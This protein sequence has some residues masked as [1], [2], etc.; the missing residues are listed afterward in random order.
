M[1]T[2]YIV[3]FAALVYLHITDNINIMELESPQLS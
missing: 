2:M 3:D 1:E